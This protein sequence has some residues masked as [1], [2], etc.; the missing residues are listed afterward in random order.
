MLAVAGVLLISARWLSPI[1]VGAV[2]EYFGASVETRDQL[3]SPVS[4]AVGFASLVLSAIGLRWQSRSF[5][6]PAEQ[7]ATGPVVAPV[8][9]MASLAVP[10]VG[11]VKPVRGRG[12]LVSELLLLHKWRGHR[13]RARVRIL[14]GRGGEGKTT[15]AQQ[16]AILAERREVSVWWISAAEETELQTGMRQLARR[17][18]ATVQELEREWV[19]NA[20]DVLWRRLTA[21]P[22]RWLL[23]IDNADDSRM[24]A[25][26]DEP[27]AYQRGWLRPVNTK[28]G[29]ILVTSREG[30]PATW[31]EWCQLHLV[32]PLSPVDGADVLL[33]HVPSH[34]GSHNDAKG[35]SI[36]LG[37]SPLALTLTGRYLADANRVPLPGGITTFSAYRDALDRGN[38]A[39]LF[40]DRGDQSEQPRRVI[41]QTWELS[42]ELL[43]DRGLR[44]AR[45]LLRLLALFADAPIPHHQLLDPD[46]LAASPLF[47]GIEAA[48]LRRVLHGLDALGL[49]NLG[50]DSGIEPAAAAGAIPTIRL[51]LLIRD[52]SL[53]HLRGTPQ[54][55]P[56]IAL[57]A[58]LLELATSSSRVGEV[59][60]PA[61]WPTWHNL[62]PH[63]V[64]ML[65]LAAATSDPDLQ[66]IANA[67]HAAL[68][69]TQYLSH[70]GLYTLALSDSQTIRDITS[71]LLGAEHPSTLQARDNL[72]LCTGQAGDWQSARDQF[73][74]LLPIRHRVL[75]PDHPDTL[76]TRNHLAEW[77]GQAGD[78]AG[79]R[80]E[81]AELLP[82][83]QRVLGPEHPDTLTTRNDL[84]LW[85]GRGGD[86]SAA[87][88]QFA[89]LLPI[90]ER[91]LGPEHPDT[92]TT[93]NDL[94]S[95]TGQA[96]DPVAARDQFAELLPIR[97]RVLGNEHPD[98][99]G[100]RGNLAT[101]TGWAG[102]SEAARDRFAELL[103]TSLQ[104]VGP[105]HPDTLRCRQGL[106]IWTG[107]AGDPAAARDQLT[108][109]LPVQEAVQGA[110][111]PETLITRT[112]IAIWNIRLGDLVLAQNQLTE[113]LP[114]RE[115][116]QGP[117]HPDTLGIREALAHCAYKAGD[118]DAAKEQLARVL[119]AQERSLGP[120]HPDTVDSRNELA[121]WSGDATDQPFT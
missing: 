50:N 113:L 33:D 54:L 57:A 86:A 58:Q 49:I 5:Q 2:E 91:V 70:S 29:A 19:E 1:L 31:G 52:V 104:L 101:W 66:T 105:K 61:A 100:T 25:P 14:Y 83:R 40:P 65:K 90:R 99:R 96:G 34:A 114:I 73:A 12:E 26:H 62:M 84:A 79:A 7:V 112:N 80:D 69:G 3:S 13:I 24:L 17:L 115:Q 67:T 15:V 41:A 106:A 6:S 11:T 21:Y 109:L 119:A 39:A 74:E 77:R 111:H 95:W 121:K 44:S 102:D 72:A 22:D 53:H 63:T 51:H 108:E 64:H 71:Q 78:P 36:R 81:L 18:G 60:D 37:G 9:G 75:G 68:R 32:E 48:H 46:V 118:W 85:T 16:V 8:A 28:R 94:A 35:L 87:R 30:D 117:E 110:S 38:L 92:L 93:R 82:I 4:L 76:T 20:P 116:L 43:A 97:E 27:V 42:L 56:T 55:R 103:N 23:V 98:T 10:A 45:T 107:Y 88:D 47:S 120:E 59:A 89:E